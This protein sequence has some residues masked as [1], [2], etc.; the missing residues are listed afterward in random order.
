MVEHAPVALLAL[1]QR[2]LGPGPL[3][4]EADR[5]LQELGVD[6]TLDEVVGGAGLHRLDVHRA[7]APA[8]E[9]DQRRLDR[10]LPRLPEQVHP[11]PVLEKVVDQVD[12]VLAGL[13]GVQS[14][15]ERRHPV[16]RHLPGLDLGHHRP[17]HLE[18][19][20]VVV[21]QENLDS[22]GFHW[23]D[24]PPARRTPGT[25]RRQI[26][27]CENRTQLVA[28]PGKRKGPG[29][30]LRNRKGEP[31]QERPDFP[32]LWPEQESPPA[33]RLPGPG[34]GPTRHRRKTTVR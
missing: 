30:R 31:W 29:K 15:L 1:P 18:V 6:L 3:Q 25:G 4:G 9:H 27:S 26:R 23:V 21:H 5:A 22:L 28:P 16:Q 7:V 32:T 13:Q 10:S 11:R 14:L 2:P 33:P 12:V 19:P 20:L 34:R 24:G 17:G 8:R